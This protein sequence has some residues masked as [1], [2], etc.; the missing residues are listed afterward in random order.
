MLCSHRDMWA[1]KESRVTLLQ[2]NIL[3]QNGIL[4]PCDWDKFGDKVWTTNLSRILSRIN[5]ES[6]LTRIQI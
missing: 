3:W 2:P 1:K 4:T 6:S 5:N